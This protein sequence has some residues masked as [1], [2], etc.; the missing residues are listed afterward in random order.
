MTGYDNLSI[1]I[2]IINGPVGDPAIYAYDR[3]T[4]WGWKQIS[5]GRWVSGSVSI[6]RSIGLCW[7]VVID[8]FGI[9]AHGVTLFSDALLLAATNYVEWAFREAVRTADCGTEIVATTDTQRAYI[10]HQPSPVRVSESG[11]F[12]L[13]WHYK[14]DAEDGTHYVLKWRYNPSTP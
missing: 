8:G 5:T 4:G 14:C 13:D 7:T 9:T 11:T 3:C 10:Q 12:E 2:P 1:T 6:L